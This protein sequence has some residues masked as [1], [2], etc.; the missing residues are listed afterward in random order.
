[1]VVVAYNSSA[2]TNCL[3]WEHIEPK[4][5]RVTVLDSMRKVDSRR[6]KF[7][8]KFPILLYD[9]GKAFDHCFPVGLTP[10]V[11]DDDLLA[12]FQLD[13]LGGISLQAFEFGE[14]YQPAE[15]RNREF[16]TDFSQRDMVNYERVMR[17][18]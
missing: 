9:S 16:L 7:S 4:I 2:Q 13:N 6:A 10:Y 18:Q 8:E 1:M 11:M 12:F 14:H 5:N 17:L 3:F 15:I